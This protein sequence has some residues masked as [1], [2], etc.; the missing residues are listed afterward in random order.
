MYREQD[1]CLRRQGAVPKSN[2]HGTGLRLAICSPVRRLSP[3]PSVRRRDAFADVQAVTQHEAELVVADDA[4]VLHVDKG[5]APTS[6]G[7]SAQLDPCLHMGPR[8]WPSRRAARRRA[9]KRI[10]SVQDRARPDTSLAPV[11]DWMA[12]GPAR[13]VTA[14]QIVQ[15][16]GM[17]VR[18][19]NRR[20]Q[21]Q[22]GT[23]PVLRPPCWRV[24]SDAAS[25]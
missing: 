18:T 3:G 2:K 4:N 20:F 11:L 13:N 17:S 24:P 15:R 10:S 5:L 25:S 16:S 9:V 6:A 23:S 19:L 22:T 12:E 7:A 1:F 14:A 8:L 21:E